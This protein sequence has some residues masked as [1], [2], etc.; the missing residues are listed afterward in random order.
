MNDYRDRLQL[1]MDRKGIDRSTLAKAIGVTYQAIR[2]VFVQN[3]AFGSQNN[4]LAAHF[5]GVDPEWLMNGEGEPHYTVLPQDIK[6]EVRDYSPQAMSLAEL[7]DQIP[8]NDVIGR[9]KA[10]TKASQAILDQLQPATEQV[11][12]GSGT[13][14]AKS[15][16]QPA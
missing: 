11:T 7:F 8:E 5:F 2:K 12:Q 13:L 15:H 4:F 16:T 6:K 14:P 10:H 3:G 1:L 9:A